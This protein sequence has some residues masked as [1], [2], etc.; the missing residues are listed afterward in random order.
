MSDKIEITFIEEIEK[1]DQN[2]KKVIFLNDMIFAEEISTVI[3][4]NWIEE[5]SF[6]CNFNNPIDTLP[7][8]LRVLK[9]GG[10]F[11][12]SVDNLP[13]MLEEIEFG[14]EFNQ[15]VDNL[16]VNIKK[17]KY[18]ANFNQEISNLPDKVEY[19]EF[20][21]HF[22]KSVNNLPLS[23]KELIFGCKFNLN[24]DALYRNINLERIVFGLFFNQPID[25]LPSSVREASF[26][27]N[28]G[29]SFENIPISLKKISIHPL[30]F[31]NKAFILETIPNHIEEINL[32][33]DPST[34]YDCLTIDKYFN[35]ERMPRL[36]RL[37]VNR[38]DTNLGYFLK[39]FGRRV[40]EVRVASDEEFE[41]RNIRENYVSRGLAIGV[42]CAIP[43]FGL[44][45][46]IGGIGVVASARY[47]IKKLF[48][49]N[50]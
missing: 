22:N 16:P 15:P 37:V 18:G 28:F 21:F 36:K 14:N 11:N 9:L 23:V 40:V 35:K 46:V 39:T 33:N 47:G 49:K 24:I 27:T 19:I 13:I 48:E 17:I 32:Y 42:V 29:Q 1:I 44:I 25:N 6:E 31:S 12:Q 20:G 10:D 45:P 41:M 2:I 43:Y 26:G 50:D 3:L 38:G 8:K 30:S 34:N 4:P 7:N 5:I